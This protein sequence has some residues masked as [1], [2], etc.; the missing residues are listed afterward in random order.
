MGK[1]RALL[2]GFASLT[3][4]WRLPEKHRGNKVR[5][6]QTATSPD[7]YIAA[8][9]DVHTH[10]HRHTNRN[11]LNGSKNTIS[12]LTATFPKKMQQQQ[13][14]QTTAAAAAA[15]TT[16]VPCAHGKATVETSPSPR[17]QQQ[18]ACGKRFQR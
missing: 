7:V 5:A 8:G 14:Q 18:R 12:P 4:A 1:T 17:D 10:L 3:V 16:T 6:L 15:M 2:L 9:G 13:Q 11:E